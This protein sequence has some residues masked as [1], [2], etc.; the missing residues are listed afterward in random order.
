MT[1][2]LRR[3]TVKLIPVLIFTGIL[4]ISFFALEMRHIPHEG[5]L[6]SAASVPGSITPE[7]GVPRSSTSESTEAESFYLYM[8]LM[9]DN[10]F[11]EV[12][13]LDAWTSD[14]QGKEQIA[15]Q[16]GEDMQYWTSGT[17]DFLTTTDVNLQWHQESP[18]G[19]TLIYSDTITLE[20]GDWQHGYTTSA[21]LCSGVFTPTVHLDYKTIHQSLSTEFAVDLHSMVL[22]S[23]EQGFDRC[24]LSEVDEMATWWQSSPYRVYNLYLGGVSFYCKDNPLDD[25]WVRQVAGQGWTFI[26]TWVGPQAP[27]TDKYAHRFSYDTEIAYDQGQV[28]AGAA[29]DAARELGFTGENIIYYD[30]EGYHDDMNSCHN[31]VAAFLRGWTEK[32]H[33]LGMKSGVY[34]GACSSYVSKWAEIDPPPDDVWIAHWYRSAYD[35]EASVWDASCV[36]NDLFTDHQRIKQYAGDHVETWGG[37]SLGIDSNVLDGEITALGAGDRAE[38]GGGKGTMLEIYGTPIDELG[39]FGINKGW[40]LSE[41]RLLVTQDSGGS[42]QDITPLNV[43]VLNVAF[44]DLQHAWLVSRMET[45]GELVISRTN[46]SGLTWQTDH[47]PLD[48]DNGLAV[49]TAYIDPLDSYTAWVV[50]RQQ[51]GSNFSLGRLFLTEDGGETWQERGVPLG[52]AVKFLDSKR[53]WVA[54]GPAGDQLY[55]THDGG[56]TWKRQDLDLFKGEKVS[57]GLPS[58][59]DGVNGWLPVISHSA[60]DSILKLY[61][62]RNGGL[63]WLIG[64]SFPVG[65]DI[66]SANILGR[67]MEVYLDNKFSYLESVLADSILPQ[68]AVALDFFDSDNGLVVVQMGSCEG[69]KQAPAPIHCEQRWQ[70]LG[71]SDGGLTWREI[72]I[73]FP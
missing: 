56:R 31:A 15:F 71:T 57:M 44:L 63:T 27:C 10:G 43:H 69:D 28:E 51:S 19:E 50:L 73:A 45:T 47:L 38:G 64:H 6:V 7:P 20:P 5:R 9:V 52:E 11:P 33:E 61:Y 59:S 26:E 48:N 14:A 2:R 42:W 62:T 17:N 54:G 58:F 4:L 37:I 34:G 46:D 35:P 1:P 3:Y 53:G 29:A 72:E 39:L 18:C 36:P 25:M 23:D 68:G 70:L 41:G 8:P 30:L 21:P 65:R 16:S 32:L 49:D 67:I 40:V 12:E 55:H 22:V 13:L 66:S 24:Y 60:S